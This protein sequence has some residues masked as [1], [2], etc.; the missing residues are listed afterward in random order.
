MKTLIVNLTRF[1]DLLQTQPVFS[2]L[3]NAG[4]SVGLVCLD[5]FAGTTA[6]LRDVDHVAVLRGGAMLSAL[7]RD[8]RESVN[9]FWA[10]CEESEQSF[11]PDHVVNLTA[12]LSARLLSRRM[13]PDSGV[14]QGFAVDASGFGVNSD[15][16]TTFLQASTRMRGCSP[17]NLVDLYF[18]ASGLRS[19]GRDSRL[20]EPEQA[21]LDTV[22]DGLMVD[23]V[24]A[25]KRVSLE[26]S[27]GNAESSARDISKDIT[28]LVCLQ[29]G[30]SQERR[31]WPLKEFVALGDALWREL[32]LVPVL[33]GAKGERGLA[34]RYIAQA[35]GPLVDRV[36]K[37][38]LTELAATLRCCKLLVSNDTGTMHLAA[39]L[40]V[41]VLA[42]FL[43]TAQPW[44]TGAYLEGSC[45]LEPDMPCHPCPFG[46]DCLNEH[47]C[48]QRISHVTVLSMIQTWCKTGQWVDAGTGEARVWQAVCDEHGFMDLVALSEHDSE[49]RTRWVRQQRFFYRQFL[50][51]AS[52]EAGTSVAD[53]AS[54][55]SREGTGNILPNI[56]APEQ[57]FSLSA[58]MKKAVLEEMQQSVQLLH[59]LMEQ[60]NV[61][62]INPVP[63]LKDRFLTTWQRLQNI[64][65]SS[66]YLNVL[67][68]LW[69]S[70]TQEAGGELDTVLTLASWYHAL[71]SAWAAYLVEFPDA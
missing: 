59:L 31:R 42:V 23:A 12:S 44:D 33:L 57:F 62:R 3:K 40:G 66:K 52:S 6:L 51:R 46:A 47:A 7:E 61:L 65:N 55:S 35:E 13:T 50:D 22:R 71:V 1:G 48:R 67:G 16:W 20:R 11:F 38:S 26:C 21:L 2:G 63:V 70:E 36:G 27:G 56:N 29:L 5:N 64:W 45:S 14:L 32:G 49:D 69:L 37:T 34:E 24:A 58:G 9:G 39:G 68:F 53:N 17:F 30:A 25:C 8:W 43:A 60:G 54:G 4:H 41:S 28:G 10:W 18:Q 19:A 15:P